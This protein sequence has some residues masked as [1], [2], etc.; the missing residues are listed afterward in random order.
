H[1][2]LDRPIRQPLLDLFKLGLDLG[3]DRALGL[4]K[5]SQA[6]TFAGSVIEYGSTL[7]GTV[8]RSLDGA[9]D[10]VIYPL[11][12]ARNDLIGT[13]GCALLEG[14]AELVLVDANYP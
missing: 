4:V 13:R 10:R 12:S 11:D 3:R 6:H 5:G 8:H 1:I 7:E 9:K 14:S 2:R